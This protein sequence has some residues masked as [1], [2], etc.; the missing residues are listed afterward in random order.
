MAAMTRR[1]TRAAAVVGACQEMLS[2]CGR[3]RAAPDASLPS[4]TGVLL[5]VA[6]GRDGT[7]GSIRDGGDGAVAESAMDMDQDAVEAWLDEL[8]GDRGAVTADGREAAAAGDAR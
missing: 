8:E 7:C 1:S 4:G 6:R 2:M 3:R 5:G